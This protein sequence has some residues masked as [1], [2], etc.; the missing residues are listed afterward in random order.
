MPQWAGSCWY[1][2]RFL[3]PHNAREPW[4]AQ[5]YA[6]WMPVD[7]YVGGSEHAVLHLLYARFWHKV[8]F[9]LGLVKDS[10]PFHKL[11][12]QGMV[13]GENN[14]KMSKARGNVVNPDDVVRGFGADALRAYEMFMGP[15]EQV[16]PWQTTGIEGVRRFLERTWNVA[17]GRLSAKAAAYDD[18]TRRMVH[19]TVRKVTLDIEGLRFNTAI[20]AMMILVKHLGGLVE[21]PREAAETLALLVSPFAPHLGEE[22]WQRLGHP[23]SLAYAPWPPF[24]P[25][26]VRDET[27]EIGVQIQGRLRGTVTLPV[28][29]D[30]EVARTVAL[31]EPRVASHLQ[32][33]RVRNVIYVKGKIINFILE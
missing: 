8:L 33:K 10:E 14:E 16:K 9:D 4:S 1:Y 6:D 32:G 28:D 29:A 13:L 20:S 26:L 17:T 25:D 7:L 3:D 31:A 18:E 21:V 23:A 11:V 5:S 15:L 24:D 2:L 30:T 27:V 22:I 19:K 12:H